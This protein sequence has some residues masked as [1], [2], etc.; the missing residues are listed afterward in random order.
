MSILSENIRYLRAQLNLSQ[1]SISEI[2]VITRS[3]YAKYEDAVSEPPLEILSKISR[4]F[5]VSI[6]LLISI[7]LRKYPLEKIL[8]LPDNRIVLP[9]IVDSTGENKIEIIPHKAQMG[10]LNSYNDPEYIEGLQNISLPFLRNGKFRAFPAE[11]DS[12]PPY[13]DGT[14]IV[15]KYIDD[16]NFMTVGKTYIFVSRD[17]GIVYK[18]YNSKSASGLIVSSDNSFYQPYEILLTDVYEIWEFACSINTVELEKESLDLKELRNILSD[19][20]SSK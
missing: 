13:K 4:Y 14:F 7:D 16:V 3:R 8:N 10:Y 19:F 1:R 18:R 17:Q 20:I 6:D 15:G 5:N 2:L 11:G 12:M 9:I